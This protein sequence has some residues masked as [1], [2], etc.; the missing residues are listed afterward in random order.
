MTLIVRK[1]PPGAPA[2]SPLPESQQI[3]LV[4]AEAQAPA[5]ES[6][7]RSSDYQHFDL[8][9]VRK[10]RVGLWKVERSDGGA[11]TVLSKILTPVDLRVQTK[12]HYYLNES[13]TVRAWLWDKERNA[14]TDEVY[15]LQAHVATAGQLPSSP[16]YLPL[17]REAQTGQYY[18]HAPGPLLDAIGSPRPDRIELELIAK[19]QEDPWFMRRSLPVSLELREPFIEWFQPP[20]VT[21]TLLLRNLP[22]LARTVA[23]TFGGRLIP[24]RYAAVGFEVPPELTVIVERFDAD[25]GQYLSLFE[26]P[27]KVVSENG[28]LAFRIPHDFAEYGD[29]R[30]GYRLTGSTATGPFILQSPWYSFHIQFFRELAAGLGLLILVVIQLI[31]QWTAKLKGVVQIQK[32]GLTPGFTSI[33]VSP[34]PVFD[35]QTVTNLDLGGTRF[36]IR[37]RRYLFLY[38][39]C[40]VTLVTGLAQLDQRPLLP[41]KTGCVPA[42]GAHKLSFSHPDGS[43]VTVTLTLV[44]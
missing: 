14:V 41:G 4:P 29:Y 6:I 17:Q 44:V 9:I 22:L 23:Y 12:P 40:C 37:P 7:Y 8:F 13:A 19:R 36:Q 26:A 15:Q 30:Y 27:G 1:R 3:Q 11:L 20:E 39:R 5:D 2:S 18:L 21:R 32:T 35:S 10:P 28:A 24:E 38:K 25:T 31:S 33:P 42:K 43:G 34:R 16:H